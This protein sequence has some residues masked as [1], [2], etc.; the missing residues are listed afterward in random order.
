MDHEL[1][2]YNMERRRNGLFM[3]ASHCYL[4]I[5]QKQRK[6][7]QI[8]VLFI[9]GS[10]VR[11]NSLSAGV[12]LLPFFANTIFKIN[13]VKS[14]LALMIIGCLVMSLAHFSVAGLLGAK[15]SHSVSYVMFDD[16]VALN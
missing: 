15:K 8:F 7:S 1:P 12:F 10:S 4:P 11:S 5:L 9:Y 2:V 14:T 16:I 3:G 13:N 6:V